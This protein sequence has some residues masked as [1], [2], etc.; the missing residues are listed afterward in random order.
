MRTSERIYLGL[1]LPPELKD[2][3]KAVARQREQSLSGL[4]RELL[5]NEVNRQTRR[6][7]S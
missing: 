7:L 6:R 5:R 3:A 1:F 4:I 2:A